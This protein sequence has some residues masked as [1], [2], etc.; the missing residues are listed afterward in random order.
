MEFFGERILNRL[1]SPRRDNSKDNIIALFNT[2]RAYELMFVHR[3][4]ISHCFDYIFIWVNWYPQ[5]LF[6]AGR[7]AAGVFL[8]IFKRCAFWEKGRFSKYV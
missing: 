4:D 6:M 5:Q 8:V 2:N 3:D 7:A 1:L